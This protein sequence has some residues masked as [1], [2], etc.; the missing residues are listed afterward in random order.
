[1][2]RGKPEVVNRS[3]QLILPN[4]VDVQAA[5][6]ITT[7]QVKALTGLLKAI[8]HLEADEIRRVFTGPLGCPHGKC[9]PFDA[10]ALAPRRLP[11]SRAARRSHSHLIEE[12]R[13][14]QLQRKDKEIYSFELLQSLVVD[15]QLQFSMARHGAFPSL[16]QELL[17]DTF[18]VR[19]SLGGVSQ[20]E[21]LAY[22]Y[23]RSGSASNACTRHASRM[24]VSVSFKEGSTHASPSITSLTSADPPQC[25]SHTQQFC[26]HRQ[27]HAPLGLDR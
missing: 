4:L 22:I 5:S 23:Q 25:I 15:W 8:S 1:M 21:A 6:V 10:G 17:V 18:I 11:R 9:W 19:K 2:L 26:R 14:T 20:V 7:V 16:D 24:L 13:Q 27:V 3:M 12:G